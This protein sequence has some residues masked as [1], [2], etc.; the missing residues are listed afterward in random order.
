M[1]IASVGPAS[2]PVDVACDSHGAAKP[3][4]A[5]G[6]DVE[7]WEDL[8]DG[9]LEAT[10]L[11]DPEQERQTFD[12]NTAEDVIAVG[13]SNEPGIHETFAAFR[14]K[15]TA[16]QE[17]AARVIAAQHRQEVE[18]ESSVGTP[19]EVSSVVAARARP[20][21]PPNAATHGPAGICAVRATC[22]VRRA[23]GARHP[24]ITSATTLPHEG[25]RTHKHVR[26]VGGACNIGRAA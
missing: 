18:T 6:D 12:T 15:L 23:T 8:D 20:G 5:K 21:R 7:D 13:H 25:T 17:A 10:K 3:N 1:C 24:D 16:L 14:A 22:P 2:R 26:G 9:S 4:A 11:T 19:A